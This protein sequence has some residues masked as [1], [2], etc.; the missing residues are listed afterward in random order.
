MFIRNYLRIQAMKYVY[1]ITKIP[2]TRLHFLSTTEEK[3]FKIIAK[4]LLTYSTSEL[5]TK[6]ADSALIEVEYEQK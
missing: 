2:L 5:A 3:A 6:I 1:L 4:A